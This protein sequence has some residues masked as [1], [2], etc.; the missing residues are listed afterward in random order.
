MALSIQQKSAETSEIVLEL[1]PLPDSPFTAQSGNQNSPPSVSQA[2]E[3]MSRVKERIIAAHSDIFKGYQISF[4]LDASPENKGAKTSGQGRHFNTSFGLRLFGNS[5]DTFAVRNDSELGLVEAHELVH[6]LAK[7]HETFAKLLKSLGITPSDLGKIQQ[8]ELRPSSE[9]ERRMRMARHQRE[10][11]ADRLALYLMRGAF[12]STEIEEGLKYYMRLERHEAEQLARRGD[13][14]TTDD[15]ER[16]SPHPSWHSRMIAIRSS[17]PTLQSLSDGA[18]HGVLLAVRGVE[19]AQQSASRSGSEE[20]VIYDSLW[21]YYPP[22]VPSRCSPDQLTK[23]WK[24][25][26]PLSSQSLF[27]SSLGGLF[28]NRRVDPQEQ[29]FIIAKAMKACAAGN[30]VQA[31]AL[32]DAK[33]RIYRFRITPPPSELETL[34]LLGLSGEEKSDFK[35]EELNE[36]VS[37]IVKIYPSGEKRVLEVP[38]QCQAAQLNKVS[39]E[40]PPVYT[41][42]VYLT[43]PTSI[44]RRICTEGRLYGDPVTSVRADQKIRPGYYRYVVYVLGQG[45]KLMKGK[46][47]QRPT[48]RTPYG[49]GGLGWVNTALGGGGT[50][51]GTIGLG[52]LSVLGEDTSAGGYGRG[53]G[54]LGGRRASPSETIPYEPIRGLSPIKTSGKKID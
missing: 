36:R 54:G 41:K 39:S 21:S 24:N 14:L 19:R 37:R 1:G 11:E 49:V 7:D 29:E 8:G 10:Y 53:A 43:A 30:E 35:K 32:V 52:N 45:E 42:M 18:I 38:S 47:V 26:P 27:P 12:S 48:D 25:L 40:S 16:V 46:I 33:K 44:A 50:G 6:G 22:S 4:Y 31:V 9:D 20:Y 3:R 28:N 13:G 2:Q 23:I 51:E 34:N 15:I 17:L 5:S